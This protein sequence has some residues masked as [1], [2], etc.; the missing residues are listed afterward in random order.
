MEE[1]K[2]AAAGRIIHRDRLLKKVGID[3]DVMIALIDDIEQFS[4]FKPKIFSRN[5]FLY[6]NYVVFSELIG[7]FIHQ[8][9]SKE[10][11]LQKIF[12]YLRKNN[13]NILNKKT[14]NIQKVNQIFED[15]KKQRNRLKVEAGNKDLE[16]I[17]IYKV[18]NI[19]LIYSRNK[20]H[21]KPYCEYVKIVFEQLQDDVDIM[22][23]QLFGWKK[24]R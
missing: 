1:A 9:Y 17:S 14:T 19:E 21:F 6:I 7:Y 5:N 11:A 22:W 23:K 12:S 18:H 13:I 24:R 8:G 3:T 10:K 16:I 2:V 20:F 4:M 15:L